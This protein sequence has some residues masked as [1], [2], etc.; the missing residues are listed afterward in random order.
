MTYNRCPQ[1]SL[2]G[3]SWRVHDDQVS[4]R[5][6]GTADLKIVHVHVIG[7]E[8]MRVAEWLALRRT[9]NGHDS[10]TSPK[11]KEKKKKKGKKGDAFSTYHLAVVQ[12]SL[13]FVGALGAAAPALPV[14]ALQRGLADLED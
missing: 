4:P 9:M 14:P 10:P 8:E 11:G 13:A 3:T 1:D 7:M 2:R 5:I 6:W 12:G